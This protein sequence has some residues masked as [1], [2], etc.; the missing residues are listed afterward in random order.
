MERERFNYEKQVFSCFSALLIAQP[1]PNQYGFLKVLHLPMYYVWMCSKCVG[2]HTWWHVHTMAR[3]PNWRSQF[4][5][6]GTWAAG[7]KCSPQ[8]WKRWLR[9]DPPSHLARPWGSL[10]S[11]WVRM[12][13]FKLP[14]KV[15][16]KK[17][18]SIN[19]DLELGQ[20]SQLFLNWPWIYFCLFVF[21]QNNVLSTDD[22]KIKVS[23]NCEKYGRGS[24]S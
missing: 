20:N 2:T 8:A 1:V 23:I 6:S 7:T 9:S 13:G 3:T 10:S 14:I 16:F 4:S 21:K 15:S 12:P 18:H 22:D 17:H 5:P 24:V 19:F 11:D